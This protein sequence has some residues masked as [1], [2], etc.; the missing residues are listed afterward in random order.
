MVKLYI[1][2]GEYRELI[3]IILTFFILAIISFSFF[4]YSRQNNSNDRNKDFKIPVWLLRAHVAKFIFNTSFEFNDVT[5]AYTSFLKKYFSTL[6]LDFKYET[7]QLELLVKN[8]INVEKTIKEGNKVTHKKKLLILVFLFNASV[9]NGKIYDKE[10]QYLNKVYKDLGIAYQVF[11]NIKLN[12]I[13]E[14]KKSATIYGNHFLKDK[15]L[16]SYK[17]LG[18]NENSD[19]KIVKE[20]Y[21]TLAKKYHPDLN[22]GLSKKQTELNITKFQKITDAY[23]YIK[24]FHFLNKKKGI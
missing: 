5:K 20:A 10:L 14:E 23:N 9:R 19:I 4:K 18:C 2:L 13:K 15:L 21:R 11:I 3:S 7:K 6:E 8:N 17:V 12:Y 24:E 16:N 1:E 22:S